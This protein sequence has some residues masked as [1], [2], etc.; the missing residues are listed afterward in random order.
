VK[1]A[2]FVAIVLVVVFVAV[3]LAGGGMRG[4]AP[5]SQFWVPLP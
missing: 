2:A 1:V 5:L 4:H 3:H